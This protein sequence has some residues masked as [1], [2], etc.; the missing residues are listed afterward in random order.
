MNKRF[1]GSEYENLAVKYLENQDYKIIEKNFYCRNGEIDIIAGNEGYLCFIE[2]KYRSGKGYGT[3]EEA[4]DY[5]K[6]KK[7]YECAR[8]YMHSHKYSTD[9]PCRFDVVSIEG[10]IIKVYKNAFDVY[11]VF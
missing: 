11:G 4:V 7:I 3:P 10:E 5:W 8:F 9:T 6:Q 1:V 2:V